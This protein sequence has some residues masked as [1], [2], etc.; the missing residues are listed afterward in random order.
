M[1]KIVLLYQQVNSII[2]SPC[3]KHEKKKQFLFILMYFRL[4]SH[5]LILDTFVGPHSTIRTPTPQHALI[6]HCEEYVF[7]IR[8]VSCNYR[9]RE[10]ETKLRIFGLMCWVAVCGRFA[11]SQGSFV[12]SLWSLQ[13]FLGVLWSFAGGLWSLTGG[14]CSFAGRLQS[15]PLLVTTARE[16]K[17]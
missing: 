14:L 16:F 10:E 13:L 3:L 15:L 17:Y 5:L 4:T 8:G 11:G 12:G 1:L 6:W 2:H 9:L 7:Q